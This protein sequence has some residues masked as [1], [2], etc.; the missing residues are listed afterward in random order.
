MNSFCKGAAVLF[1]LA[2]GHS[3]LAATAPLSSEQ[4]TVLAAAKAYALEYT[5]KL[6]N[7]T[8]T[9]I[10]HR[11]VSSD[12]KQVQSSLTNFS[13]PDVIGS[14]D[15]VDSIEEKLTYFKQEEHYD[16]IAVNGQKSPGVNHMNLPGAISTGEFGTALLAIF[17]P[18]SHA[19]FEGNRMAKLRGRR[20]FVFAYEVPKETGSRI[21][22]QASGK[23]V[24]TA[25]NGLVFV[26]AET[27]EIM[28]ITVHCEIPPG[29]PISL[30][31]RLVEYKPTSIAGRNY[32]LPFHAELR[33]KD[34]GWTFVNEIEFKAYQK[35]AAESTILYDGLAIQTPSEA[36]PKT[37]DAAARAAASAESGTD[38]TPAEGAK[39]A[40]EEMAAARPQAQPEVK[41]ETGAEPAQP[42]VSGG[43]MTASAG[44][45]DAEPVRT[46]KTEPATQPPVASTSDSSFRLHLGVDLVLVPVVV[47]D[48]SGHAV[49]NLTREDFELFDKGKRQKITSFTLETGADQSPEK[50]SRGSTPG[51]AS[52]GGD[53]GKP[54]V[55]SVVYLFDDMHLK[56][57]DLVQVRE[58]AARHIDTLQAT[59]QAAIL[60]TSGVVEISFTNDHARL[61][62]ALLR[63]R[64][65]PL[66]KTPLQQCPN[67]SYY[68]ADQMLNAYPPDLLSN[69]PL[70]AAV[71]EINLCMRR[72]AGS[73]DDA[74]NQALDAA[75]RA[76][77]AGENERR[78]VLLSIKN[79]IHWI[80]QGPGTKTVILISPGFF[81][82]RSM[83][84]DE[85]GIVDEAIRDKVVINALDAG[86]LAA[87][88][89]VA[90]ADAWSATPR[91]T[92]AK[93]TMASAEATEASGFLAELAAGTGGSLVRNTNDLYG[94]LQQLAKPPEYTYLLGFKPANL[95]ANGSFHPLKVNLNANQRLDLQARRGYFAISR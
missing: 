29:F 7:F 16:V 6:P 42:V 43:A 70:Q 14:G 94:G 38:S 3:G 15:S 54:P 76:E 92:T 48:P 58:A 62:E 32:N 33:M 25:Y 19:T 91:I 23:E 50:D 52:K 55:N 47:R 63:L 40:D 11:E 61:H 88:S 53:G 28:R 68:Q 10:T 2:A 36:L 74:I 22:D 75:R 82:G 93:A 4:E 35:F 67:V 13:H 57:G 21:F 20:T 51:D 44:V 60:S 80:G 34:G 5:Q 77:A 18:R 49:G 72:P 27:R 95:K 86:G 59:D 17:D 24:I 87:V 46:A 73:E 31:E 81:L 66:G 37:P 30:S 56:E 45:K 71:A 1:A 69:P 12:T 83:Q 90:G 65:E 26:D 9:Q 39:N 41:T 79:V 89:P 84:L 8:C 85:A 64:A 78:G